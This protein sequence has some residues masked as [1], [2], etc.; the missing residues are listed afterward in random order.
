MYTIRSYFSKESLKKVGSAIV[1]SVVS[2]MAAVWGTACNKD[3]I[4]VEKVI[5]SLG[6]LVLGK[7]KYDPIAE[8]IRTDLKWMF[9]NELSEFKVLCIMNNIVKDN[10]VPFFTNYFAKVCDQH[11]H[12][13]R[14][15]SDKLKSTVDPKT[16]FG[17]QTFNYR[18][19][20]LWNE[21]SKE[22]RNEPCV[23]SFKYKLKQELL[24]R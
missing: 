15:A 23:K 9:P 19:A 7:R 18:G 13:T 20:K 5:R 2:Y 6:R 3:L 21:M 17:L 14:G 10:Q 12:Y 16:N 4:I 11:V 22:L 1:L 8:E 24:K